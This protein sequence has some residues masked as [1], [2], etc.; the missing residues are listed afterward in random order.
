MELDELYHEILHSF[1]IVTMDIH[2][3]R[4]AD[5]LLA[6]FHNLEK[7]TVK[8]KVTVYFKSTINNYIG[9]SIDD[10]VTSLKLLK[11]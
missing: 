3:S 10:A 7:N 11:E 2:V 6:V 8:N 9:E 4:F 5:S 1:S